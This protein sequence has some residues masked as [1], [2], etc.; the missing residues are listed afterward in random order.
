MKYFDVC[1]SGTTHWRPAQ[2]G[3]TRALQIALAQHSVRP[4]RELRTMYYISK[5][6]FAAP[7]ARPCR[8]VTMTTSGDDEGAAQKCQ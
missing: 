8:P 5:H 3:W 2:S 6:A 1:A 4:Y 7:G